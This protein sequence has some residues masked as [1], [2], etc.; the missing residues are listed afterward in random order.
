MPLLL[1][2]LFKGFCFGW[3]VGLVL[4]CFFCSGEADSDDRF[5]SFSYKKFSEAVFWNPGLFFLC[6]PLEYSYT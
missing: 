1:V 4:C 2:G 5:L 3:L 6:I